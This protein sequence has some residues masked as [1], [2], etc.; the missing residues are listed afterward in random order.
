MEI[1]ASKV[2]GTV[3]II[4]DDFTTRLLA[5]E[6]LE[7]AGFEVAETADGSQALEIFDRLNPE[8]I[9]LDVLMP[10][11]DGFTVCALSGRCLPDPGI[12]PARQKTLKDN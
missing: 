2:D 8:I 10:G 11:I 1:E 3:L 12:S 6:S 9:L 7:Q 4:D 5:R